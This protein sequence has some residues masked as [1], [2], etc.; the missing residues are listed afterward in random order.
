MIKQILIVCDG[1]GDKLNEFKIS[2][3]KQMRAVYPETKIVCITKSTTAFPKNIINEFIP[4]DEIEKTLWDDFY[5]YNNDPHIL[6]GYIR[7]HYLSKNPYTLYLDTDIY[8]HEPI[9]ETDGLGKFKGDYSALWNGTENDFFEYILHRRRGN[10]PLSQ[11]MQ[12][13]P[14]NCMDLSKF[15]THKTG[16]VK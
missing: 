9:K 13:F 1:I 10:G 12:F 7:F 11:I 8:L 5:V 3:L 15:M 16:E 6:S 2:C 4:W 14:H